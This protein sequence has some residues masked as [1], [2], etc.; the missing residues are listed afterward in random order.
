[1]SCNISP[2]RNTQFDG[3]KEIPR[4][5][6]VQQESYF[7][8]ELTGKTISERQNKKKE[9]GGPT[10]AIRTLSPLN[11][12]FPVNSSLFFGGGDA[13]IFGTLSCVGIR[14]RNDGKIGPKVPFYPFCFRLCGISWK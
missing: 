7:S 2:F 3:W 8:P 12:S 9:D 6:L 1:M 13:S 5:E 10:R 4:H 14:C 11:C